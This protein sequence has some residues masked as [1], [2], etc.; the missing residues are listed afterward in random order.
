MTALELF[1]DKLAE[2]PLIAI[3]RGVRPDEIIAIGDA[4][5]N[6]GI[7]IIEVP[8]NSPDPLRSIETLAQHLGE[9]AIVGAGTVLTVAQVGQV[10]A[11]GGRIIVSPSSD[12]EV[13]AASAA[14]GMV[15]APGYFTPSE[16]FAALKAGAHILKLFP[17]E[18][19][20]PAVVRAQRAVLPKDVPLI[21]VGGVK[22]EA[23]SRW[24]E[25]GAN[26]FGLGSAL[27]KPGQT[28]EQVSAQAQD[29]VRAIRLAGSQGPQ[30]G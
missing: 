26:G 16:A 24:L 11:A 19:A 27:Y 1:R 12:L 13:I 17:A 7:G 20:T 22:P 21:I 10:A 30:A 5:V 25:A 9:R 23:V 6:A 14:A 29:F 3:L 18:A 28:A 4:L 2:C 8:L 15:S